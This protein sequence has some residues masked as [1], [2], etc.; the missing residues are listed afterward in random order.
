MGQPSPFVVGVVAL[1]LGVA[2]GVATTEP[3]VEIQTEA[4]PPRADAPVAFKGKFK[5]NRRYLLYHY[6]DK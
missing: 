2:I 3:A 6:K 5:K 4:P 1:L